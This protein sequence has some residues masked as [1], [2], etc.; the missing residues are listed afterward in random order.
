MHINRDK[1]L[2]PVH[3]HRDQMLLIGKTQEQKRVLRPHQTQLE[4]A[5]FIESGTTFNLL[6]Y[7]DDDF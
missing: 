5:D 3:L 4:G 6:L 2:N 7:N 1:A